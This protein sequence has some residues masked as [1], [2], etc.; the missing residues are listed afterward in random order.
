VGFLIKEIIKFK[1][2]ITKAKVRQLE[3]GKE[4]MEFIM[5]W[6]IQIL[7]DRIKRKMVVRKIILIMV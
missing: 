2:T 4:K 6:K 3:K 1:R 5:G 7:I